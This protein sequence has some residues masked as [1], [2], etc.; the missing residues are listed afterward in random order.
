MSTDKLAMWL[1]LFFCLKKSAT[2]QIL[3]EN[4]PVN[5]IGEVLNKC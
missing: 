5:H 2:F 1:Q 3:S 4:V